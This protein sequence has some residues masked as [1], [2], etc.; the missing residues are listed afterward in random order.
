[1]RFT[2]VNM[3]IFGLTGATISYAITLNDLQAGSMTVGAIA[4]I[5][6]LYAQA[7]QDYYS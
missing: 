3:I 7:M 5:L 4:G 2:V 6:A 1:M